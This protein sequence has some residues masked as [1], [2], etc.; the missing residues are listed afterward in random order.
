MGEKVQEGLVVE[1]WKRGGRDFKKRVLLS[2]GEQA[3]SL[4]TDRKVKGQ[5]A[6][7]SSM[8]IRPEKN[9]SGGEECGFRFEEGRGGD[10]GECLGWEGEEDLAILKRALLTAAGGDERKEL[11]RKKGGDSN[12]GI[13]HI[14]NIEK[15]NQQL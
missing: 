13:P 7:D 2:W 5:Y 4:C 10:K 11:F 1:I 6:G 12:T 3:D 15:T 14:F 9:G 8:W